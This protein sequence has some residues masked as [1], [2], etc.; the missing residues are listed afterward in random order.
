MKRIVLAAALLAIPVA[1]QGQ[2]RYG[3]GGY[4]REPTMRTLAGVLP[5]AY[6]FVD[7]LGVTP[8]Q[9][10]VL[11]EIYKEWA[12]KKAKIDREIWQKLPRMTR[13]DWND[14]KKRA[15]HSAK[16]KEL[17][18]KAGI[19][20]PVEKVST[21]LTVE[22]LGKILEAE[23][24]VNAWETWL[25]KHLK[26]Y[27]AKLTTAIG[28]EDPEQTAAKNYAYGTLR[29]YEPGASRLAGRLEIADE[30][31]AALRAIRAKSTRDYYDYTWALNSLRTSGKMTYGEVADLRTIVSSELMSKGQDERRAQ[32]KKLLTQ[33]QRDKIA[34]GLKI[35][36]ERNKAIHDR[37]AKYVAELKKI[38]PK[39][40]AAAKKA[41]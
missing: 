14:P 38:L 9:E 23:E 12:A 2:A 35:L 41:D 36:E 22:Q 31:R 11:L 34:K 20:P 15:K 21:V 18:A 28:P 4:G 26:A 29:V 33:E 37:Y 5:G 17:L 40:K 16:R 24:V 25:L 1:A 8:E 3:Y 27:D 30:Q 39:A 32:I 13:A 10:K 7:R 19:V 6:S